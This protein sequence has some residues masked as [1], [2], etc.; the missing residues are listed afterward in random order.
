MHGCLHPISWTSLLGGCCL[1]FFICFWKLDIHCKPETSVRSHFCQI[2]VYCVYSGRYLRIRKTSAPNDLDSR[3][4]HRSHFFITITNCIFSCSSIYSTRSLPSL[5]LSL[6]LWIPSPYSPPSSPPPPSV[7]PPLHPPHSSSLGTRMTSWV[8]SPTT[9]SGP[10]RSS[11]R[12]TRTSTSGS[13]TSSSNGTPLCP[14]M[15]VPER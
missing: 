12:N 9:T 5:P 15:P 10:T 13:S 4:F 3:H 14:W 11:S 7:S 2:T 1:L 6:P 8:P